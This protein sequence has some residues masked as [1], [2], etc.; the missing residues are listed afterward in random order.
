MMLLEGNF[1]EG[2]TVEVDASRGE[3]T[4]SKA[5]TAAPASVA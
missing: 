2:D 5:T 1:S 4:F 3:L